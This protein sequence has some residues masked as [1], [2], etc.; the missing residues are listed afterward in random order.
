MTKEKFVIGL[1]LGGTNIKG[2]LLDMD[3]HTREK[4]R[5]STLAEQG[6]EK[7]VDRMAGVVEDLIQWGNLDKS[8]ILGVGVGV[9]G[10]LDYRAGKVKFAPNLHWRDFPL[11]EELVR[12]L[13]VPVFLENDGNVAALGEKWAGAAREA[14]NVLAITIGTG[15]GG[16]ILVDGRIYRGSGGSA[17]EVGHMIMDENGPL[18]NCGR[19]GCLETLTAAP[20]ILRQA[21]EAIAAGRKTSLAAQKELDAKDVFIAAERG[22][23]V[24]REIIERVSH[25]L[26]L[27]IANLINVLNPDMVVI[28]GG[29]ARAGDILINPIREKALAHSLEAAAEVVRI[30]PAHLG[31]DAGC[32]GA[33]ALV[34]QELEVR[35]V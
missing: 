12:R 33:G 35:L 23:L 4:I 22:D 8:Q 25:Y 15:I 29:V 31:N 2:A 27:A 19:R 20:A 9:P 24:A 5:I 1:D 3:G 28:G 30:V 11:R 32:I 18:C 21:R 26:G 10:Q 13:G 17:A 34:F 6:A 14:R 7:V 16:G